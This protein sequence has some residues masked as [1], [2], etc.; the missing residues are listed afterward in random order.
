MA[1]NKNEKLTKSELIAKIA[2][3]VELP[4]SDVNL[5]INALVSI[6]ISEMQIGHEITIMQI[7][8]PNSPTTSTCKILTTDNR[9]PLYKQDGTSFTS[10]TLDYETRTFIPNFLMGRWVM[11]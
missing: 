11:L 4:K 6:I 2:E 5:T 10:Y 9:Y 3:I 8:A 7:H 1:T